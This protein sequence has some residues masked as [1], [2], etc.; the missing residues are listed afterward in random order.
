MGTRKKG[1]L[2]IFVCV[3]PAASVS[4]FLSRLLSLFPTRCIDGRPRRRTGTVRRCNLRNACFTYLTARKTGPP[5]EVTTFV[6]P[7]VLYRWCVGGRIWSAQGILSGRFRCPTVMIIYRR[8]LFTGNVCG[9][10][11][12]G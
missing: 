8:A 10:S 9:N 6:L 4:F 3:H 7:S 2:F 12:F 5:D 11:L 1:N